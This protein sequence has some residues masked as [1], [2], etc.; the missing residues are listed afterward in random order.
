MMSVE[1]YMEFLA[2]ETEVLGRKSPPLPL[3]PPQIPHELTRAA[4]LERVVSQ[5]QRS[6]LCPLCIVVLTERKDMTF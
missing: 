1:E 4:E 2:G 3:C 6:F 5:F